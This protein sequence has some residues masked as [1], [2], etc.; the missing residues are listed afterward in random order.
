MTVRNW[1]EHA[2]SLASFAQ[3]TNINETNNFSVW[4]CDLD[5]LKREGSFSESLFELLYIHAIV[6]G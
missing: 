3:L 2:V 4:F 5:S 6:D 1:K